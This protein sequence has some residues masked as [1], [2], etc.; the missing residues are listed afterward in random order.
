[1]L[2]R[3]AGILGRN[4]DDH[5]GTGFLSTGLLLPTLADAG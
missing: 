3:I 2:A 1:L 4:A 5:L